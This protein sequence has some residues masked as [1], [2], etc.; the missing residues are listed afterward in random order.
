MEGKHVQ[1]YLAEKEYRKLV[2]KCDKG[3]LKI[4]EALRKAIAAFCGDITD[5]EVKKHGWG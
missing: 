4:A 2:L 1:T 3:K 5:A